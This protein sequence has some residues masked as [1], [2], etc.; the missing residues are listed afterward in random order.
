M[1]QKRQAID[2]EE[3]I[4]RLMDSKKQLKEME[5][6][7]DDSLHF[8]LARDCYAPSSIPSFRRSLYDGYAIR[9]QDDTDLPKVFRVVGEVPCGAVFE[10]DLQEQETVRIMTGAK[11][12]DSAEKVIMLEQTE[13]TDNAE[14]IKIVESHPFATINPIGSDF[15]K[16]DKILSKGEKVNSGTIS[17]LKAF[18]I[19]TIF[20]FQKPKA[21]VLSTGTELLSAGEELQDGKVYDSNMPLLEQ[22]LYENGADVYY[23]A[24]LPDEKGSIQKELSELAEQVDIIVTTGGVSVGDFDYMAAIVRENKLLFNKIRMR[25]GSPTSAAMLGDTLLIALSGNPGACFIGFHLF[26]RNY[27]AQLL[28]TTTSVIHTTAVL[29]EDYVKE[30]AFDRILRGQYDFDG[31]GRLHVTPVGSDQSSSLGNLH[32]TTC[33]ITIPGGSKGHKQGDTVQVW[34]L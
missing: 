26:I 28:G 30:N 10:G 11:V 20:V 13:E 33:L 18:G 9:K 17:L 2:I 3:A 22:L 5:I 34:L 1:I 15:V 16:G 7:V 23:S 31:D 29:R 6:D 4:K 14:E 24:Q 8:I 27:L 21:A 19:E 12:P 25:P 32:Q